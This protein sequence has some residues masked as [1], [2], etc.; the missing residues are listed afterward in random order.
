MLC[1]LCVHC[2]KVLEVARNG[3]TLHT[4][5]NFDDYV[6]D[7]D[8]NDTRHQCRR[9]WRRLKAVQSEL[10]DVE[11]VALDSLV[12]AQDGDVNPENDTFSRL[13]LLHV[14]EKRLKAELQFIREKDLKTLPENVDLQLL[15]LEQNQ[16]KKLDNLRETL[17]YAEALQSEVLEDIKQE[18]ETHSSLSILNEVLKKKVAVVNRANGDDIGNTLESVLA[19]MTTKVNKVTEMNKYFKEQL[20]EIL[21]KHFPLPH[22]TEAGGAAQRDIDMSN[23]L[24]LMSIVGRLIEQSLNSPEQPYID[25][26]DRFWPPHVEFLLRCQIVLK[27]PNNSHRIKLVPFHL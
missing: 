24:S 11:S 22:P 18:E 14:L 16:E 5:D 19:E 10:E 26:D 6:S 3:C 23:R 21:S 7:D 17:T 4:M 12:A 20:K 13:Q 27:D 15:I 25:M 1:T 8:D 9:D 2:F